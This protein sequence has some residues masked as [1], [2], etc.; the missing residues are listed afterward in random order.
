MADYSVRTVMMNSKNNEIHLNKTVSK[1]EFRI[2]ILEKLEK[3]S[4]KAH[5]TAA[6]AQRAR[7]KTQKHFQ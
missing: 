1:F 6:P 7:Q 2:I 4:S 3:G 5:M